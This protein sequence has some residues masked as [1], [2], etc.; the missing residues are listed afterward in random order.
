MVKII[1]ELERVVVVENDWGVGICLM[2]CECPCEEVIESGD[3]TQEA[4]PAMAKDFQAER[5]VSAKA[6][7]QELLW[8]SETGKNTTDECERSKEQDLRCLKLFCHGPL[9]SLSKP[10]EPLSESCF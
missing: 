5:A 8:Y 9:G 1:K 3:V 10:L 6:P 2:V 7:R 4:E